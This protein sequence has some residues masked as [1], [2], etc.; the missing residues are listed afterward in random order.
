M[1]T[2]RPH[3]ACCLACVFAFVLLGTLASAQ[4][5]NDTCLNAVFM[6][7]GTP[8][9]GTNVGATIGPEPVAVC[10]SMGADVWF[11]FYPN[12]TGPLT[13][14]TCDPITTF[15][16]VIAVWDGANGCGAL[17]PLI[18][19][20]D[21]CGLSSSV[22]FQATTWNPYYVSVGGYLGAT[23]S[24]ML[25]VNPGGG[26]GMSLGFF[27]SGPGTLGYTISSG[28]VNGAFIT[29]LT[30][31]QGNY[32]NGWLFGLDITPGEIQFCL[33]FGYPFSG[34]LDQCGSTVVGPFGGLPYGLSAY[35]VAIGIPAGGSVPT[36]ISL[37]SSG[38]VP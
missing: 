15:D 37:A 8:A 4:V 12:C 35:A 27:D 5:S 19:N 11:V 28:P 7:E 23:G 32:P 38:T 22:T 10:G 16:T 33:G 1:T 20:D 18:C 17:V 2:L 24:F 3:S 25:T 6:T 36:T 26:T 14:T 21:N 29:V 13:V 34:F 9:P 30:L 31:N